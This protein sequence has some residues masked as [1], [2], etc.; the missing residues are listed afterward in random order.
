MYAADV[1]IVDQNLEYESGGY[2]GTDLIKQFVER[3]FQGLMCIRS[4][5]SSAADE[6][7]YGEAGAQCVLGKD[8]SGPEMVDRLAEAHFE[9]HAIRAMTTVV[10]EPFAT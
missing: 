9:I 2:Q 1:V 8:M 7:Q 6:Q 3:G 5:N 4:A 10:H